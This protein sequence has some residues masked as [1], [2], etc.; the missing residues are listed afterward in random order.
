MD[1]RLFLASCASA[2]AVSAAPFPDQTSP[3]RVDATG[4]DVRLERIWKDGV[5]TSRLH[6]RG[7]EP[8]RVAQVVLFQWKHN[9]SPET[10]IYG[11][12]FQML[13]QTGG[14]LAKPVDFG[15]SEPKH[16]R[17]PQPDGVT[18]VSGLLRLSPAGRHMLLAWTS[19][20]RFHGRFFI[21]PGQIEAILDTEGLV[22]EPGKSW[23]MEEFRFGISQSLAS[24]LNIVADAINRNHP[25]LRFPAPPAGWCSWYCF[26]PRVTAE[27]VRANLASIRQTTPSLRYIQIDDGY[28]PAMG[29][30]L[31]T[32]KAFGGNVQSVLKEIRAQGFEPAIWVAP[33]IA[34]ADSKVFEDNPDWFMKGEDGN[35]IPSNRVTFGGWRFGPWYAMD[36]THPGVQQHFETLFR[37]MRREWGV[38]YFKLDANFWGAMHGGRLH[39]P[40][41]TRIEAYRRGMEAVRRGS[42]DA[43]L[44]ACN[45]PMWASFGLIHGS[46]SSADISRKWKTFEEIARQNLSRNWQNGKLWWNDPDAVT[47]S[48]S[49]PEEEYRFHATVAFASGGM[50]LSGDDLTTLPP[51]RLKML[52]ALLPVTGRAARFEETNL[53]IGITDLAD[54]RR[55]YSLFNW[56]EQPQRF[57]VALERKRKV[58]ELWTGQ[59]FGER[60]GRLEIPDVPAHG[61][62]VLIAG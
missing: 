28:Q 13:S 51:D 38:T 53:R 30:W 56:T 45:H 36:G 5:C 4:G 40:N 29:D 7:K 16:Y 62:R 52:H 18:A 15:Y 61:G 44:L 43:F 54:G 2:A 26:G 34:Q 59:D 39:D 19:C 47:L 33:F 42:G 3:S 17:I 60:E 58:R 49:L 23:E 31:D 27:N 12:S 20:R 1:R 37:T 24:G 11:E 46:R 50:I 41:A 9:L 55:A 21:S 6:N 32:G 35:P 22:L 10:E 8:A 14:T 25:P 57:Q 48:G